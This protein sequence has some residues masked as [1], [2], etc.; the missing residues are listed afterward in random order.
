MKFVDEVEVRVQAGNGGNG[1]ASFRREKYIPL[2]GPDGG[3]GGEQY[4]AEALGGGEVVVFAG[5]FDLAS[6]LAELGG[7][8]FGGVTSR[9]P[10]PSSKA[11]RRPSHTGTA[12]CRRCDRWPTC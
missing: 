9:W 1:S 7:A 5:L 6:E 8:A 11:H 10:D 2:G 12:G 4:G 3:D